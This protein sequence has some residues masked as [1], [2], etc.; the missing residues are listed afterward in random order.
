MFGRS[1]LVLFSLL[2]KI[3]IPRLETLSLWLSGLV[4]P[5][6]TSEDI[7]RPPATYRRLTKLVSFVDEH[8]SHNFDCVNTLIGN[9]T[10]VLME[11]HLHIWS[12][13]EERGADEA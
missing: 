13:P 2:S 11:L 4:L 8:F 3:S 10:P 5:V 6:G 9:S 12:K 7:E 1:I